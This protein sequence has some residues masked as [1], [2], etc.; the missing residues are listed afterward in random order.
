M[1]I[2]AIEIAVSFVECKPGLAVLERRH[3]PRRMARIAGRRRLAEMERIAVTGTAGQILVIAIERPARAV[4]SELR[5]FL[6]QMA[7]VAAHFRM[8]GVADRVQRLFA[9]TDLHRRLTTAVAT[10]AAFRMVARCAF[11]AVRFRVS[12]VV[13][14][15][16]RAAAVCRLPDFLDG[17]FHRRIK[18]LGSHRNFATGGLLGMADFTIGITAPLFVAAET[19]TVIGPFQPGLAQVFLTDSRRVARVACGNASFRIEKAV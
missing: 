6:L 19:L 8:A 10:F 1:A 13:E 3:R 18:S 4:V 12:A 11:D 5:R 2:R 15:H 9:V 14:R 16:L 17:L 7:L